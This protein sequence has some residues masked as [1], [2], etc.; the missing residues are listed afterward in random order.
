VW[1]NLLVILREGV[2]SYARLA[3]VRQGTGSEKCVG[4]KVLI[5]LIL[6]ILLALGGAL[7]PLEVRRYG[8]R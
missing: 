8:F 3:N 6:S 5:D 4:S 7:N 1:R 2:L